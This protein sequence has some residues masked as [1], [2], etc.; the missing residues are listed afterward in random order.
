MSVAEAE[1]LVLQTLNM[2]ME[3]KVTNKN[4]ALVSIWKENKDVR[5][6]QFTEESLAQRLTTI[7][8]ENPNDFEI[9]ISSGLKEK[10]FAII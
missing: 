10:I 5:V 7:R 3:N 2:V 9:L 8:F 4:V 1:E 6:H